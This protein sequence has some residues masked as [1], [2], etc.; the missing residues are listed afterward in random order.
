MTAIKWFFMLSKRLYKKSTFVALLVL[1]PLCV[2][3]LIFAANQESGFVKIALAQEDSDDVVSSALVQGFLQEE[4]LILFTQ[5]ESREAAVAAVQ[6][7]RA[8][9]AWVFP[10]D[11]Q[12]KIRDYAAE[13]SSHEPIVSVIEREQTVFTRLSREKLTAALFQHCSGA[14]YISFTKNRVP[15]PEMLS[16]T[17]LL[18]CYDGISIGRELFA[19]DN[20]EEGGNSAGEINYLTA[21]VRGLLAVLLCLGGAAAAV[22]HMQDEQKGVFALVKEKWRSVV[23]FACVMIALLNVAMVI[24]AAL[25]ATG[26]AGGIWRE[27]VGMALYCICCALFCLLLREILGSIRLYCVMLPLLVIA[28]CAI[29]P[30]F[31]DLNNLGGVAHLL[32]PTYYVYLL[33]DTHYLLYMPMYAAA[34]M[35]L[36]LL[37]R[38]LRHV[39][40]R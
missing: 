28:M 33:H 2:S 11:M 19:F 9:A 6:E 17:M 15:N 23:A 24:L 3:I 1:I 5:V 18:E 38:L 40:K 34:L 12:G 29:C 25:F 36:L 35:V 27:L 39:V 10:A 22:L 30:V 21:P 37:V 14:R 16:D 32:P 31:F 26:L 4:S 8:D 13:D 20:E 7:G